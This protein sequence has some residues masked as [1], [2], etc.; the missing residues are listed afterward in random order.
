MFSWRAKYILIRVA[1]LTSFIFTIG[2]LKDG[3]IFFAKFF[4][5]DFNARQRRFWVPKIQIFYASRD[6]KHDLDFFRNHMLL[7]HTHFMH[8]SLGVGGF[9]ILGRPLISNLRL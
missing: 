2:T 4:A 8:G 9:R 6:Y 1:K 7:W 5:Q 3:A